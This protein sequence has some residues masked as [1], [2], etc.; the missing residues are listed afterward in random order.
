[1]HYLTSNPVLLWPPA[2]LQSWPVTPAP[3]V[4]KLQKGEQPNFIVILV[5]DLG[6]DDIGLHHPRGKD[7][8]KSIGVQTPNIDRLIQRGMSF[9]NFYTAPLCAM[10][11]AE[12]LTGRDFLR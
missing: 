5:D 9:S 7:G 1:V 8:I 4:P 3:L 10:S 11:R 12:L 2:E 6:F